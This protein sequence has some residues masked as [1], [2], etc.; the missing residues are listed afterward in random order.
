MKFRF[1]E[2]PLPF[3]QC[4][5]G[6]WLCI[7]DWVQLDSVASRSILDT[8]FSQCLVAENYLKTRKPVD[9]YNMVKWIN[10]KSIV[11][12]NRLVFVNNAY[13]YIKKTNPMLFNLVGSVAS[14]QARN[15]ATSVGYGG[16]HNY[17]AKSIESILT[18]MELKVNTPIRFVDAGCGNSVFALIVQMCFPSAK[19]SGF[20]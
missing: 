5:F 20:S 12:H 6:N 18:A 17:T 7:M 8:F 4:L 19:V 10:K 14:T 13:S 11:L 9:V 15:I 2:L 1:L 16:V 3:I